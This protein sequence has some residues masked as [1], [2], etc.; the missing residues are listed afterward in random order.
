MPQHEDE[1]EAL[2]AE[3]ESL[4][5]DAARLDWLDARRVVVMRANTRPEQWKV[6]TMTGPYIR[7]RLRDAIDLAMR[8]SNQP[9][10]ERR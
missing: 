5:A 8:L 2:R 6:E 9:A 4:R 1:V 3:V 7:F 10:E